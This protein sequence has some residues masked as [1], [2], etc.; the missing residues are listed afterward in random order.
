MATSFTY[1]GIDLVGHKDYHGATLGAAGAVTTT[2]VKAFAAIIFKY[3]DA[4]N[5]RCDVKDVLEIKVDHTTAGPTNIERKALVILKR[6]AS[7]QRFGI[8]IPAIKQS[9]INPNGTAA[10]ELLPNV[11]E[12]IRSAFVTLSDFADEDVAVVASFSD[13]SQVQ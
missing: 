3:S 8:M 5:C 4:L 10:S 13:Y 2:T 7:G 1:T 11:V 6:V 9:A 12:D